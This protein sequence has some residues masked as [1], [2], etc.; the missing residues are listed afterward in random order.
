MSRRESEIFN[1]H[2][3]LDLIILFKLFV[4]LFHFSLKAD[5]IKK[6]IFSTDTELSTVSNMLLIYSLVI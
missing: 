1:L 3:A 5:K 6:K 4:I 2:F